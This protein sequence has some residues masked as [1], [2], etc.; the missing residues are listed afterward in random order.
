MNGPDPISPA[1]R[2]ADAIQSGA[3]GAD[4]S[5][6]SANR[7]DPARPGTARSGADGSGREVHEV[8][9]PVAARPA[10]RVLRGFRR[11]G[12]WLGLWMLMIMAVV[13]GSLLPARGLPPV[14]FD[15]FDK[16][17]HLLGYALLSAYA[18]M[19]FARMR[20]RALAAA[21]LVALGIGL[22]IAQGMLTASRQA[23]IA[24]AMVNALGVLAG[25]AVTA[26]P[27]AR[28]LQRLDTRL[29]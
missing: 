15:G 20:A 16:V 5:Q 24:D 4:A 23:D 25:L 7:S 10:T 26:T 19:L 28:L 6:S 18:A 11:P 17:Q 22:E 21:G 8:R 13:A 29:P 27:L 12:L 9:S 1:A 14:L 2:R 3:I